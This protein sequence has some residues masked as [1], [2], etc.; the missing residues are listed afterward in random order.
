MILFFLIYLSSVVSAKEC[1]INIKN[2]IYFTDEKS[3]IDRLIE[4]S[5][6]SRRVR[7]EFTDRLS[8]LTGLIH[9]KKLEKTLKK[10]FSSSRFVIKP[11]TIHIGK[12]SDILKEKINIPDNWNWSKVRIHRKGFLSLSSRESL[13]VSC[14]NCKTPGSKTLRAS[15]KGKKKIYWISGDLKVKSKALFPRKSLGVGHKLS[16]EL[17]VEKEVNSFNPERFFT[18]KKTLSFFKLNKSISSLKPLFN[19]DL[20]P[21]GLVQRNIPVQVIFKKNKLVLI[22]S[23]L[24]LSR[25]GYGQII[26]LKHPGTGRSMAGR[27]IGLNKVEV[28]R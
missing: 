22:G 8:S 11:K 2:R 19:S 5:N 15:I 4:K 21:L 28:N 14:N 9:S 3:A 16:E 1:F 24:P 12:L 13:D 18:E 10:K 27:I 25:G 17:F 20:V 23:A 6:C 7:K 26:K